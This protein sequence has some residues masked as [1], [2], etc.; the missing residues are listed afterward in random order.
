MTFSIVIPVYNVEEYL[1]QCVDSVLNQNYKQF[2]I[3]L[4]NDGSS[5]GSPEICDE[6]AKL[7]NITVFHKE[8][9]GLSEARND[10]LKIAK[11]EYVVFLDS[12]DYWEG[13][14]NLSAINDIVKKD[15]D[16]E[17]IL[18]K[19]TSMFSKNHF[20]KPNKE[21]R[22][23][24]KE[25]TKDLIFKDLIKHGDFECSACLK[26][27]K[28]SFLIIN[29][30]YFKKGIKSED[31]DWFLRVFTL[32][33]RIQTINHPFYVYR[34]QRADSI[35]NSVKLEN[36]Q[37]LLLIIEE[38]K[39]FIDLNK[40]SFSDIFINCYNSYLAYQL[41]IVIGYS[42]L[43]NKKERKEVKS[44]VKKLDD[45]LNFTM[46]KKTAQIKVLYNIFG[47]DIT[48]ILLYKYIE[49]R[50]KGRVSL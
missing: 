48:S 11:G 39:K 5:D 23:Y 47:F 42:K 33:K 20:V 24:G 34:V 17:I 13:S 32:I 12:D 41:S 45:L 2:E 29:N 14:N 46:F 40:N 22:D 43:L 44:K 25:F 31:I 1:N 3:I 8:N 38:R 21:Y 9:E 16:L 15:K 50:K 18:F 27:I 6:Y 10:G 36:V 49:N 30:L 35:T 26:I 19:R 37:D 4:V 7:E 28:R